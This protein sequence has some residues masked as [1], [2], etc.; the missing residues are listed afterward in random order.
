[1]SCDDLY[2]RCKTFVDNLDLGPV[3]SLSDIRYLIKQRR[4]R[5]L[6]FLERPLQEIGLTGVWLEF[7]DPSTPD[8]IV[9]EKDTSRAHQRQIICHEF[10]HQLLDHHP[11]RVLHQDE[12]S[13]LLTVTSPIAAARM[14]GRHVYESVEEH[15]AETVATLLNLQI[16]SGKLSADPARLTLGA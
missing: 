12:W 2:Y 16:T 10:A 3:P 14:L 8:V 5:N 1:M 13:T 11:D 9:Y 4:G 6:C 7:D 15:E